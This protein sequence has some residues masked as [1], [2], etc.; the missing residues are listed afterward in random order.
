VGEYLPQLLLIMGPLTAGFAC[1]AAVRALPPSAAIPWSLLAGS[2]FTGSLGAA[3]LPGMGGEGRGWGDVALLSILASHMLFALSVA[4]MIHQR[5][6]GRRREIVVDGALIL[7][8]AGAMLLKWS[9]AMQEVAADPSVLWTGHVFETVGIPVS[10]LCGLMFGVVL[11]VARRST[12]A[13]DCAAAIMGSAVLLA[14]SVVP[15][16]IGEAMCCPPQRA[17]AAS[18]IAAWGFLTFAGARVIGGGSASFLV[19]EI[20]AGGGRLRQMVAPMAAIA[21]ALVIVDAALRPSLLP[22]TAAMLGVGC[23]LLGLRVTHLLEVTRRSSAERRQLKQTRALVEVSRALSGTMQLDETLEVVTHWASRLLDAHG[24]A[25]ELL[26][27]DGERLELRAAV[28]LPPQAIGLTSPVDGS[29]TGWVVR[30]GRPRA[31]TD[32]RREP[33]I[34]EESRLMLGKSPTAA[35]PMRYHDR[36]LGVLACVSDRPFEMSDFELLGALADQAAVAIANARLF[37]QVDTLS[38][39]DPLT[40]L[41]N[42]RQLELDLAREFAAAQRGRRLI[43]VMFDVNEFKDYNDRYGHLAGDEVLRLFGEVL[44]AET[45]AMNPAARYGGDEFVALLTDTDTRGAHLFTERVRLHFSQVVATMRRRTLS[46]AAGIAHFTPDMVS[47][48]DLI[49]AADRALY[50][51]KAHKPRTG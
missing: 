15:T 25:L 14:I 21:M 33:D 50:A 35:V 32:P 42:R 6:L 13:K 4:W 41:S 51:S 17:Y 16:V 43:A 9:P 24:A 49:D 27:E 23:G 45:R 12:G 10:A 47:P 40:G 29:F 30:H 8:V 46:V 7:A 2:A 18:W 39:T 1:I 37:N 34:S 44:A 11:L 20:D 38:K 31:T 19:T 22:G 3:T 48:D 36:T 28:G 26:S 5:D